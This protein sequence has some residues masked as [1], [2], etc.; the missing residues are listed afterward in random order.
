ME[1]NNVN[2][3]EVS[4]ISFKI[5]EQD[6]KPSIVIQTVVDEDY[7]DDKAKQL[8]RLIYSIHMSKLYEKHILD[9]ADSA[10]KNSPE[11]ELFMQ[12]VLDEIIKI[13]DMEIE[14]I[15]SSQPLIRPLKALSPRGQ[16]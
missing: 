2:E 14:R 3:V 13:E 7:T 8:G 10:T 16:A 15:T 9:L 4:S 1:D 6:G 5:I 12:K 11:Y